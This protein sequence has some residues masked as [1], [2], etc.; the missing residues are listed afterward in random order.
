MVT[1]Q[2]AL[3]PC[4]VKWELIN[5]LVHSIAFFSS[6]IQVAVCS[7]NYLKNKQSELIDLTLSCAWCKMLE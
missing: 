7:W 3:C 1:I 2:N 6:D 5:R 4:E